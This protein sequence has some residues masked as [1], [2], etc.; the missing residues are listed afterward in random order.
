[1][2]K[3]A[4]VTPVAARLA[5]DQIAYIL[6]RALRDGERLEIHGLGVFKAVPKVRHMSWSRMKKNVG[7]LPEF[8]KK[9]PAG[10]RVQWRPSLTLRGRRRLT[11][12]WTRISR[13]DGVA[14]DPRLDVRRPSLEAC[15]KG[16]AVKA[17]KYKQSLTPGGDESTLS[18]DRQ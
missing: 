6:R 9:W 12:G 14:R 11:P 18:V 13:R 3:E 2:V 4:G 1:M 7:P 17:A 8:G 16:A 10:K 5:L 15:R